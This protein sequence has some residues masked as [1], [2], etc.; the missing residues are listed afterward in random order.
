MEILLKN[1][2]VIFNT[3]ERKVSWVCQRINH[4]ENS[5]GGTPRAGH[6]QPWTLP[7]A[8]RRPATPPGRTRGP[9]QKSAGDP[10]INFTSARFYG[11]YFED[12]CR[13]VDKRREDIK[14][15]VHFSK[16]NENNTFREIFN[17]LL[18]EFRT[19]SNEYVLDDE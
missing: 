9:R 16:E 7:P 12:D 5:E 11:I 4:N 14:N 10:F 1:R 13:I 2:F 3:I 6:A 8:P 17:I 19:A 18:E 15:V